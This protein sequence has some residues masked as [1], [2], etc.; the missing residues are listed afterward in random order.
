MLKDTQFS[1]E[2]TD[3]GRNAEQDSRVKLLEP[4]SQIYILFFYFSLQELLEI[5]SGA[6]CMLGQCIALEPQYQSLV[7]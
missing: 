5:K 2:W 7:F 1:E 6:L 4:E 3:W